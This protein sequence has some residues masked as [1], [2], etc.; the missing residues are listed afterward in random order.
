MS[1]PLADSLAA[2]SVHLAALESALV[3]VP[4]PLT[5]AALD[6]AS[7]GLIRTLDQAVLRYLKLQDTLGEQVLRSFAIG[8]LA[9]PLEGRPLLDV[10]NRLEALG[11]LTTSEWVASRALRN[12]LTHDYPNDRERQAEVLNHLP[13]MTAFLAKLLTAIR[14]QSQ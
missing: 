10:V 13:R 8:V 7:P 1:L 9:E 14:Q 3:E 6:A 5:A 11:F 2:C 4:I 12:Q